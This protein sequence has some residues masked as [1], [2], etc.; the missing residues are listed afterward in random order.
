M[1]FE[2]ERSLSGYLTIEIRLNQQGL[3]APYLLIIQL[4]RKANDSAEFEC[5]I[6]MTR[7]N[8]QIDLVY[9]SNSSN[10]YLVAVRTN[11]SQQGFRYRDIGR[12]VSARLIW[13]VFPKDAENSDIHCVLSHTSL[14]SKRLTTLPSQS[15]NSVRILLTSNCPTRPKIRRVVSAPFTDDSDTPR[16]GARMSFFCEAVTGEQESYSL[17]M[18]FA[19]RSESFVICS[20]TGGGS[21][22]T[23]VP[24]QFTTWEDGGCGS[25]NKTRSTNHPKADFAKCD[26]SY[27]PEENVYTRVIEYAIPLITIEHFDAFVFCET[28]PSWEMDEENRLLSDPIDNI[29]PVKPTLTNI[30]IGYYKWMCNVLAYPPPT[31][32]DWRIKEAYP[33]NFR[34]GL[35]RM[36]F[37]RSPIKSTRASIFSKS[38]PEFFP[39]KFI[40][41][42]EGS[43]Y[44]FALSRAS[45]SFWKVGSWGVAKLECEVSNGEG[46]VALKEVRVNYASGNSNG[47]WAVPGSLYPRS[48]VV[49]ISEPWAIEC[50]IAEIGNSK[51]IPNLYLLGKVSFSAGS[52][53]LPLFRVSFQLQNGEDKAYYVIRQFKPI[54][55]WSSTPL[56]EFKVEIV[57]DSQGHKAVRIQIS[58]TSLVQNSS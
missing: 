58:R 20:E 12:K 23:T 40:P 32:F 21:V 45:P 52:L 46:D 11:S 30:D 6:E 17:Q 14:F 13:P 49:S 4:A 34:L 18:A 31:K 1:T 35:N 51:E 47:R 24:C 48:G 33:W 26:L 27:V 55:W 10:S 8:Y 38:R 37:E 5:V 42:D 29:F 28:L 15:S 7:I 19:D 3:R 22:N 36:S 44:Y 39:K 9:W 53:E 50:P 43:P 25:S 2:S 56:D 41:N 54:G 16:L 57:D